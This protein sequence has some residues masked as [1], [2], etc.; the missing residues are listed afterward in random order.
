MNIYIERP[1]FNLNSQIK[2][3]NT[4]ILSFRLIEIFSYG[5]KDAIYFVTNFLQEINAKMHEKL[6]KVLAM[7]N[8][9]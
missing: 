2:G 7:R 3:F 6:D 9:F 1:K 4:M 8:I 5:P